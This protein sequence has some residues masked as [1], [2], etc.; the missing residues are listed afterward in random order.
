MTLKSRTRERRACEC[1]SPRDEWKAAFLPYN[2][3]IPC[4]CLAFFYLFLLPIP[5][6]PLLVL[7][8][9]PITPP[10]SAYPSSYSPC[11]S[12]PYSPS[13]LP[14]SRTLSS[15]PSPSQLFPLLLD[16]FSLT[17]LLP[18]HSLYAPLSPCI[19]VVILKSNFLILQCFKLLKAIILS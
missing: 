5:S 4:V 9:T 17:P 7:P 12:T 11:S 3:N 10:S 6:V 18:R 14:L 19:T 2:V 16:P 13:P 8:V 15:Y 1:V